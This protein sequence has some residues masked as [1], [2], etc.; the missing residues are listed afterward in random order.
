MIRRGFSDQT[1]KDPIRR[2]GVKVK[3]IKVKTMVITTERVRMFEMETTTTT[4]TS[5]GVTMVTEMIGVG[6]MFHLKIGE[7]LLH[8]VEVVWCELKTCLK[9]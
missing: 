6:H 7:F 5:I 9:K 8:M 2:I 3:E 1:P 4:T